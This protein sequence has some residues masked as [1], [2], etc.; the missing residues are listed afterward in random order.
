MSH[1]AVTFGATLHGIE[2]YPVIVSAE[3]VDGAPGLAI[4]GYPLDKVK[5]FR[6]RLRLALQS[7]GIEFD[8]R[9]KLNF[10]ASMPVQGC[11]L[12]LPSAVAIAAALDETHTLTPGPHYFWGELNSNGDVLLTPGTVAVSA[13]ANGAT[14]GVWTAPEGTFPT[15]AIPRARVATRRRLRGL[16]DA[17]RGGS[18]PALVGTPSPPRAHAA[19][20]LAAIKGLK[21]AK[22]ALE[23][24]AAGLHS[25]LIIGP[26]GSGKALLAR[27]L[28]GL[29]PKWGP[30]E[31]E[32]AMRIHD[33]AGLDCSRLL[34]SRPFRAPHHS[35]GSIALTGGGTPPRP[36]ECSLAND[37]VLFLDEITEFHPNALDTVRYAKSDG[38]VSFM[39]KGLVTSFPTDF[40]LVG[41]ANPC[42]C[43]WLGDSRRACRC[44]EEG[45]KAWR[46]KIEQRIIPMFDIV[47][48]ISSQIG[49]QVPNG[50]QIES[51]EDVRCRVE[52]ATDRQDTRRAYPNAKMNAVDI[53]RMSI[54][55]EVRKALAEIGLPSVSRWC[56]ALR[57][58]RT[59]ADLAGSHNIFPKHITEAASLGVLA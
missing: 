55:V 53:D 21:E 54:S 58:S 49:S 12:D 10:S 42:P 35:C 30:G 37:G 52:L 47:V 31:R 32:R 46:H 51:S 44:D 16:L 38:H 25:V 3:A 20:D 9:V 50:D 28:P 27:A 8:R 40:L 23:I 36:G 13:L 22:R 33:S 34:G 7:S 18:E 41:A 56:A 17:L 1:Q 29:M 14:V 5:E 48:S 2:A 45:I 11:G 6:R 57:V 43:G 15:Q 26:A 59:I 24:A 39:R 19:I 4:S